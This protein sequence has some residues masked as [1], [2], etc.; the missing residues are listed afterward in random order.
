MSNN[1]FTQQAQGVYFKMILFLA[2][3]TPAPVL[4]RVMASLVATAR[5]HWLRAVRGLGGCR[6]RSRR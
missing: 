6:L 5:V 2:V 3:N 1:I 4:V